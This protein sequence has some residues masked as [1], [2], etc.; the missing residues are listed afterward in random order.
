MVGG[1]DSAAEEAVYLTKYA[2]KVHLLVRGEQMRASKAMQDRAIAHERV[3]VHFNTAIEDAYGNGVLQVGGGQHS[4]GYWC[5]Q[6]WVERKRSGG[7][8]WG[9][10]SYGTHEC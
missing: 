5:V 3:S 2:S 8:C 9:A 1:G 4:W 6:E 10:S 7:C